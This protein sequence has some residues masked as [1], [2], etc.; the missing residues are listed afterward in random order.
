MKKLRVFA[1]S[2]ILMVFIVGMISCS[3]SNS[4]NLNDEQKANYN[5]FLEDLRWSL[6]SYKFAGKSE[7]SA[8]EIADILGYHAKNEGKLSGIQSWTQKLP[9]H[10]TLTRHGLI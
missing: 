1:V 6:A 4:L 10:L 8:S 2:F 3:H 9:H 7:I 5:S